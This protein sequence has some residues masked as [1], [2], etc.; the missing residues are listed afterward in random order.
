MAVTQEPTGTTTAG[1]DL[2]KG[3]G[4]I[5]GWLFRRELQH[6]P[7][8]VPRLT[9]LGI[10]VLATC[11]LY[12]V[13]YVPGAVTPSLLPFYHMSFLFYIYLVVVGNAVAAFTAFIGGISDKIGRANMVIWGLL[14]VG[15]IQLVA[16]P[17][18]TSKFGF[19]AESVGIGFVEG[20]ILVA[21]PALIRDFSP[22][23]GR[24]SAMGFWTLGPV[25][26]SLA[27]N[28]VATRTIPHL[29]PWQDQFIISGIECLA[30]FALCLI[31]L[32]ELSPGIRDQLMVSEQ[33][34]ALV[35]ARAKGIDVDEALRRPL[36]SMMKLDLI[37]SSLGISTFLLIYYAAVSVFTLYFAVVFGF[38]TSKADAL[39][40]WYWAVDAVAL[41]V[42]GYVSDKVRVRKPFML[43][44]A[45]GAIVMT[46]LFL[47][48]VH[49][50]TTG[51]Y[52]FVWIL[53]L[54]GLFLA[55]G[56][57]PW[58][59]AYTEAVEAK[60]PA[61][62]A[63]GLAVWAWV[64]RVVVAVSF[65]VLPFVVTSA[66]PVVDH[67]AAANRAELIEQAG[68]YIGPKKPPVPAKILS[69]LRAANT[70][71][72]TALADYLA[73]H[74]NISKVPHADINQLL[75]L[76]EFKIALG[77][78]DTHKPVPSTVT[79]TIAKDSPQLA[80][81]YPVVI[82]VLRAKN[83]APNQWEHWWWVCVGGEVLFFFLLFLSVGRWSPR[84]A[85][86]DFEEH[87]AKVR[88]ELAKLTGSSV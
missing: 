66:S 11:T 30:M 18:T 53:S 26:G 45:V 82:K 39:N 8:L 84:A 65:L 17:N 32:R 2:S 23:L 1:A 70:P 52:T 78:F 58:M 10:V 24:A 9:F 40:T 13:Y 81:F 46:I 44:G 29:P 6:Y 72:T 14:L 12:Y 25:L 34:R 60:N 77:D 57:A 31:G 48:R 55:L 87:E 54:L 42:I 19:A 74:Q 63:T 59:A 33:E 43:V 73:V 67:Q 38:S 7:N 35:E 36:R 85:K 5:G 83:E 56:Y 49:H 62:S 75:A 86:R 21:T 80:A 15:L 71:Y 61:L 79:A 47:M 27:A 76:N 68:N 50:P 64:L 41:V 69:Q 4:G 22:Q 28:L 88:E 51:Y 3:S 37:A 20:I 16:I